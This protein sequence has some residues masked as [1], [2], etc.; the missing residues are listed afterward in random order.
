MSDVFRR[1]QVA[2]YRREIGV[3]YLSFAGGRAIS[4]E[5]DL[6]QA[7][8]C[9]FNTQF[10]GDKQ[11]KLHHSPN[12]GKRNEI[13]AA[14]FK[15]MGVRAGF[16]DLWISLGDGKTGFIELKFGKNGLTLSQQ[17]YRDFLK[18][19]GHQWALCRSLDEFI[20]TLKEWGVYQS[21][22]DKNEQT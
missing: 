19:E 17:N 16:P 13:E 4:S 6:Q 11:L 22:G 7:C 8:V 18:K 1:M 20:A 10:P 14:K 5:D 3:Q 21:K 12:G 9:W 15:R 2:E